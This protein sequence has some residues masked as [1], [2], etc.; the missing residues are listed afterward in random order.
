[1]T[2]YCET[3]PGHPVHGPYH[4]FEY[5]FPIDDESRLFERLTLEIF[6]AGLSWLIILKKRD[7]F[8]LAFENYNVDRIAAFDQADLDRLM[9]DPSI[10]R[11]RRK[12]EAVIQNAKVVRE[13]RGPYGGFGHW[14]EAHHPLSRVEWCKLFRSTFS[15]MGKEVV[16]EFLMSIGYLPGAHTD[17]CPIYRRI[18]EKGPAWM[19]SLGRTGTA[20]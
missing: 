4:D 13:L 1:M 5:G 17:Q 9:N 14:V 16:G 12:I 20:G 18:A 15:F 7:G 3:A 19:R 2:S 6:Q 8:R 11:N 10:I